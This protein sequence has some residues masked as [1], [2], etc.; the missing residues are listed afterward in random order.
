MPLNI[1]VEDRLLACDTIS[2]FFTD[3]I[4]GICVHVTYFSAKFKK[5]RIFALFGLLRSISGRIVNRLLMEVNT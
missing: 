5:V 1:D 4:L 3:I 2:I